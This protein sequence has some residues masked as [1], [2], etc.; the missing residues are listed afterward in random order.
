MLGR[1][2]EGISDMIPDWEGE[3]SDLR[4]SDQP[5]HWGAERSS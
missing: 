3:L 5:E 4:G 2:E 1:C